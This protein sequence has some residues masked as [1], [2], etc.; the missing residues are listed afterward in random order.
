MQT[1]TTV[2]TSH[3]RAVS[4]VSSNQPRVSRAAQMLLDA[5]MSYQAALDALDP[6]RVVND[7]Y[8]EEQ[9][10]AQVQA[11]AKAGLL[12]DSNQNIDQLE[13]GAKLIGDAFFDDM[14]LWFTFTDRFR[15]LGGPHRARAAAATVAVRALAEAGWVSPQASSTVP[16]DD[17]LAAAISTV[18][19]RDFR[20]RIGPNTRRHITDGQELIPL[21]LRECDDVA[22][23]AVTALKKVTS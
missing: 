12:P 9:A 13:A 3:Q 14:R 18:L 15:D 22:R 19:Q 4:L 23:A 17:D 2:R 11:L 1:S 8:F 6:D 20:L 7:K 16:A 10:E 21:S 5:A